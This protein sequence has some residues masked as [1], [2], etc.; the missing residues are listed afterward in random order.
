[1]PQPVSD[2]FKTAL[3]I[4][5][6]SEE[7]IRLIIENELYDVDNTKRNL[8]EQKI[9]EVVQRISEIRTK[10]MKDAFRHLRA[11]LPNA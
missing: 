6:A 9:N 2:S 4:L 8:A 3:D 10:A 11:T 1:M 7:K 5:D